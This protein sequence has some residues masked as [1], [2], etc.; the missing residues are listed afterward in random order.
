MDRKLHLLESFSAQGADGVDYTVH[1]NEHLLRD[2]SIADGQEHWEPTGVLEYRLADG[3][4]IDV[5]SDGS[6]HISNSG[7]A[8]SSRKSAAAQ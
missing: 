2:A 3:S 6:M 1:A 8:L 4:R 7:V 5:A